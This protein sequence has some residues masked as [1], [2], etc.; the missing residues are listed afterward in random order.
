MSESFVR[1][2][3]GMYRFNAASCDPLSGTGAAQRLLKLHSSDEKDPHIIF[4]Y[5]EVSL[6]YA[7][8]TKSSS[9]RINSH[10]IYAVTA[11]QRYP[12]SLR[13]G[14][15][16]KLLRSLFRRKSQLLQF[17]R[18]FGQIQSECFRFMQQ[19]RLF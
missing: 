11:V 2:L 8:K 19:Q 6:H 14:S 3:Q 10:R 18:D 12:R 1:R 5:R 13:F 7:C 17:Q 16:Q 15:D 9:V 4:V